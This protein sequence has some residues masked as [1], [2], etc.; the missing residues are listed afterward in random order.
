M[1]VEQGI[2]DGQDMQAPE[3]DGGRDLHFASR[4]GVFAVHATRGLV[5]IFQDL[6]AALEVDL[7]AFGKPQRA[8]GADDERDPELV[9]QLGD[10]A[11]HDR[12]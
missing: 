12:G 11:R 1:S 9:F 8:G 6:P 7:A 3:H 10:G 4:F 5:V 2:D